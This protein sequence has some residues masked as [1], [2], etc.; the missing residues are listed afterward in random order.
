[1]VEDIG[2]VSEDEEEYGVYQ[3]D[4]VVK[5]KDGQGSVDIWNLDDEDCRIGEVGEH[6]EE[7]QPGGIV[8]T[9]D[10]FEKEGNG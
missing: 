8:E 1:M 3:K 7:E 10:A 4:R 2:D 6:A 5:Y 9:A